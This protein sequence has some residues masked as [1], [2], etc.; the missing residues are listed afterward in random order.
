MLVVGETGT[1]KELVAEAIHAA[2][3][4]RGKLVTVDCAGMADSLL[5]SELFG[6]VRGAFTGAQERRAGLV[7]AAR[8]GTLFLDEVGDASSRLQASL[9]RLLE[10]TSFRPVGSDHPNVAEVRFVA[11]CQPSALEVDGGDGLRGDLR[12]RLARWVI[13]LPPLRK[14]AEDIPIL[15]R[16]FARSYADRPLSI[17]A[18]LALALM[19]YKWP[20]N[21]RELQAVIEQAVVSDSP[22]D[23]LE[24]TAW[25]AARLEWGAS[26]V[27][28]PGTRSPPSE[29][30]SWVVKRQRVR[31]D[32]TDLTDALSQHGGSVRAVAG[33]LG[34]SRK[35][36]YRWL[37]ALDIDVVEAV[38]RHHVP[39]AAPEGGL[40]RS[41]HEKTRPYAP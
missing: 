4:R 2:S 40:A 8:G 18:E 23:Q 34:V 33:A 9:L 29:G 26:P 36:V 17:S 10:T 38:W 1:G 39:I 6:H 22:D 21:I 16:H 32:R 37:R 30:V 35:T 20:H 31:P 5:A 41:T 13:E 3:G 15:A 25:L 11:A 28:D 12:A 27:P 19:R 7:E 14:R 24:R